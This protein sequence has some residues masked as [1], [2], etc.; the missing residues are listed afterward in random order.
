MATPETKPLPARRAGGKRV[1]VPIKKAIGPGDDKVHTWPHLVRAEFLMLD[2]RDPPAARVVAPG[3]RAARGA[4]QPDAHAEPVEGAVVL[5]RPAGDARLLRPLARGR[6]AAELHHRRADGDPVHRHQPEGE[7]LLLLEGPQV[8]AHDL[9]RRLPHPVGV[10]DHHRHVPARPGLELVLV[11]GEVGPAQGRVAHQRRP[12]VPAR[13][14]RRDGWRRSSAAS[15]SSASSSAG[16]SRFYCMCKGVKGDEFDDF[17]ARWGWPRFL[18]TAFLSSTCGRWWSRCCCGTSST[19]STSWSSRRR[20]SASTSERGSPAR[21]DDDRPC[22]LRETAPGGRLRARR[23]RPLP[24]HRART[25]CGRN[26]SR[27]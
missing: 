1:E 23:A 19:S 25:T 12:A 16:W 3:R 13:R 10:A 11:L 9:L 14:A 18:L 22:S 26:L 5:P 7:R 15:S 17:M 24:G 20:T 6:R 4:G 21:E 27:R 2:R 8:G